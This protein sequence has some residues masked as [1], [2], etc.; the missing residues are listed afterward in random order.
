MKPEVGFMWSVQS[1]AA[2]F[3]NQKCLFP[4]FT[5]I[6]D[7]LVLEHDEAQR[8]FLASNQ[9][10]N[11]SCHQKEVIKRLD[12]YIQELSDRDDPHLWTMD[13]LESSE[14]WESIRSLA[15]DVIKAMR[16]EEYLPPTSEERGNIYL[17]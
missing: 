4:I 5:E 17:Q 12:H 3:R 15:R 1:L 8:L 10:F 6:P 16:W 11:L 2:P 14:E 7:E 9:V 13:A